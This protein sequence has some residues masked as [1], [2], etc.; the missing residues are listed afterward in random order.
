MATESLN[1]FAEFGTIVTGDN[2]IGRKNEL[3]TIAQRV[4]GKAYGNLAIVGL[5][6][7]G[8]SCLAWNCIMAK[9]EELE[10]ENCIP[11]FLSV[12]TCNSSIVFFRKLASMV[13]AEIE[14]ICSDDRYNKFA[15]PALTRLLSDAGIDE[16]SSLVET[17]FRFVKRLGFKV[18]AVLDEF[19]AAQDRFSTADFQTL[20]ELS[21][22]PD[23]KICVVTTSRKTIEDIE[24]LSKNGG[25]S[26]LAGVFKM[27]RLT[28]YTVDDINEYWSIHQPSWNVSDD[29]KNKVYYYSGG[30]PWLMDMINYKAFSEGQS[31]DSFFDNFEDIK[32]ELMEA[33]DKMIGT[34]SNEK[35]LDPAIQLVVGPMADVDTKQE[36]KLLKYGFIK[37]VSVAEKE[38]ALGGFLVGPTWDN[39]TTAYCCFS[40]YSTLDLY[41][42]YY[43]NVP[44]NSLWS[45]TENLLRFA[46]KEYLSENYSENWEEDMKNKLTANPPF[47]KFNVGQWE[48][49]LGKLQTNAQNMQLRFP[50][51][52]AHHLVDYTLTSQIF[53]MFI[54]VDWNWYSQRIF[55]GQREDW[56]KKFDFL[57]N[58]RDPIA[59]NNPMDLEEDKRIAREYCN[60]IC[61]AIHDWQKSR[62]KVQLAQS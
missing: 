61:T 51:S 16:V 24:A 4:M 19:D 23:M 46:I 3:S 35:L 37:K 27:L 39:H 10:K 57:T 13:D 32:I 29:F 34:L 22:E 40:E 53:T 54:K 45:D 55:K 33:F 42:R 25:I 36:E 41:R 26:N 12:A 14:F 31:S 8:K 2:F 18:I 44:Y 52:T 20:R 43:A 60:E 21:Y 9:R 47:L 50:S 30:H 6:R 11:I 62:S 58:L 7:I 59:H 48:S 56:F 28:G 1:P 15:K 49:N 17:Y 5:P 38:C